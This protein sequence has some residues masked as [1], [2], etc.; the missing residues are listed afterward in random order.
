[1]RR[2]RAAVDALGAGIERA[3]RLVEQL[4]TLARSEPGAARGALEPLDLGELVREALADDRARYAASRGSALA[5]DAE[6]GACV[7]GERSALS[8]LVRNLVDNAVR[9]SPA[10]SRIEVGVG[11]DGDRVRAARRRPRPGHSGRRARAR[12]RPLLPALAPATRT[13]PASASRSCAASPI[14][15]APNWRWKMR[16]PAGCA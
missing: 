12:L 13:A 5:F 15:T 8:A 2:A 9:Y 4:L 7:R 14:G 6:P 16:R 3:A 10:G 1:M 11:R